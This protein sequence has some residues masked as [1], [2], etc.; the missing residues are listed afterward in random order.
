MGELRNP[1]FPF[2][3]LM[4]NRE[5][6]LSDFNLHSPQYML[7]SALDVSLFRLLHIALIQ[8]LGLVWS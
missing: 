1:I 3:C 7:Y 2:V 6:S 8:T 4:P 5:M